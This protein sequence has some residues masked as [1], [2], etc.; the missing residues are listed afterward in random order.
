M[1]PRKEEKWEH[2]IQDIM[3]SAAVDDIIRNLVAECEQHR[4]IKRLTIDAAYKPCM[5]LLGQAQH[6]APAAQHEDQALPKEDAVHTVVTIRGLT[7]AVVG[8]QAT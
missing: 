2:I 3:Q 1:L 5:P 7:G 4:E 8:A 6:G